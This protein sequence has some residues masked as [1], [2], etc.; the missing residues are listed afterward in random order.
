MNALNAIKSFYPA[1]GRGDVPA[2]LTQHDPE[3]QLSEAE[4]LPC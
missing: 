4:R 2:V 1:L 3:V